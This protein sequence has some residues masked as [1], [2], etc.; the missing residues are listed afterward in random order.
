MR[1]IALIFA[2]VLLLSACGD[3][4]PSSGEVFAKT[5]RPDYVTYIPICTVYNSKGLCA[6]WGQTPIFH[7]ECWELRIRNLAVT[8][9]H[10]SVCVSQEE[11]EKARYRDEW[12]EEDFQ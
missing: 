6:V 4:R 2:A 9:E 12:R 10:W 3:D 7:D 1:K 8:D 11:W 5:Y